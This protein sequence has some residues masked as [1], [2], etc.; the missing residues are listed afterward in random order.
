MIPSTW[1][2]TGDEARTAL[3]AFV[4]HV[5]TASG[6]I[7]GVGAAWTAGADDDASRAATV[8]ATAATRTIEALFRN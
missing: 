4:F 8:V 1:S 3:T 7:P 2:F 6:G 5:N